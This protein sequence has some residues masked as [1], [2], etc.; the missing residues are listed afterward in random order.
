MVHYPCP[1]ELPE[2]VEPPLGS[3]PSVVPL[4]PGIPVGR[5]PDVVE[6]VRV[7]VPSTVTKIVVW[8]LMGQT[9]EVNDPRRYNFSVLDD[10]DG[11]SK[12]FRGAEDGKGLG[13]IP[14][15]NALEFVYMSGCPRK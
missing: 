11:G 8:V 6:S 7:E 14:D 4:S 15:V 9:F 5:G 10:R 13:L 12:G 3:L 1:D 2:S